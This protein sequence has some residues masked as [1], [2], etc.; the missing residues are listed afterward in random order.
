MAVKLAV[1]P[2]KQRSD[3]LS[4]SHTREPGLSISEAIM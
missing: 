3:H 4:L 2:V 1:A